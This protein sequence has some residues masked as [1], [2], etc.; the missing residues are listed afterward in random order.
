MTTTPYTTQY[1]LMGRNHL[2][3]PDDREDD[4]RLP[5]AAMLESALIDCIAALRECEGQAL[6]AERIAGK[7]LSPALL[8]AIENVQSEA[9]GGIDKAVET[10]GCE[11]VEWL[12]ETARATSLGATHTTTRKDDATLRGEEDLE[13]NLGEVK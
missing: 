12:E 7:A 5:S 10:L 8:A 11:Y 4:R 1:G 6:T 3:A 9:F 2:D 13:E